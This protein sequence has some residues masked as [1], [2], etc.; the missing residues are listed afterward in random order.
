VKGPIPRSILEPL[1]AVGLSTHEIA[2]KLGCS[3]SKISRDCR[4]LGLEARRNRTG[5]CSCC[6]KKKARSKAK[7]C[8]NR[9]QQA[10]AARARHEH[11]AATGTGAGFG[12][13]VVKPFVEI[14]DGRTCSICRLTVWREKPIPLV[15][16]HIDGDSENWLLANLRLVC[17]NCDMQLPTYK[18]RNR[19][20]GRAWRRRRYAEGKSY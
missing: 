5:F 3:Q 1:L 13:A 19:G 6:G 14:R 4:A 11:M 12:V 2:A 20:K 17:G 18:S 16:D 10:E 9:C 7:F 15:L 8:S